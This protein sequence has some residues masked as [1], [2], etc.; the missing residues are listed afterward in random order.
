MLA[1]P[2]P[3]RVHILVLFQLLFPSTLGFPHD[4]FE[5]SLLLHT[6]RMHMQ[7]VHN[8]YTPKET[9]ELCSRAGTMKGNMRADKV[10]MSSFLAGCILAFA[11]AANLAV[12]VSPW[13]QE[14][15]PG[16][17]TMLGA[18]I[19]PFGLVIILTTG[20]DLC[21][22]SFMVCNPDSPNKRTPES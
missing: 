17:I 22:G 7:V 13:Y 3:F 14:N 20:A 2:S 15:A 1:R 12:T 11:C 10:F 8:A 16:L 18:I 4:Y 19:F 9:T 6:S 5:S 21:T